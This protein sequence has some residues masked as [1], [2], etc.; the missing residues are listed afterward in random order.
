MLGMSFCRYV[1]RTLMVL[2]HLELMCDQTGQ[3]S[4]QY[5]PAKLVL[6]TVSSGQCLASGM[7]TIITVVIVMLG[8]RLV[9][10]CLCAAS[11]TRSS[12]TNS[13][14]RELSDLSSSAT[15]RKQLSISRDTT[16]HGCSR[17]C[18][19]HVLKRVSKALSLTQHESQCP[20]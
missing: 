20:V 8:N 9:V 17:T 10:L 7:K 16:A 4:L 12:S 6:E 3:E 15:L 5:L 11:N 13:P 2:H 18:R 19:E 1:R 14:L